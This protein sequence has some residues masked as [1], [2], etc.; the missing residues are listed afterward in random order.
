MQ[1][2]RPS[3]FIILSAKP[4]RTA[5]YAALRVNIH[6]LPQL[7]GKGKVID[8][9]LVDSS[10]GRLADEVAENLRISGFK[11]IRKAPTHG[12]TP[13][14]EPEGPKTTAIL[15]ESAGDDSAPGSV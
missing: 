14:Q 1:N 9:A 5:L 11:V 12:R 2:G 15:I 4:L 10:V 8:P 13:A 3:T 6:V 7:K